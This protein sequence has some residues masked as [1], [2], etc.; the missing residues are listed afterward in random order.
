MVPSVRIL[1]IRPQ[2]EAVKQFIAA[3]RELAFTY[4]AVGSTLELLSTSPNAD[5]TQVRLGEGAVAFNAARAALGHWEQFRV[6]WA[7]PCEPL[8]AIRA[9]EVAAIAIRAMG[10]WWLNAARIVYVIEENGPVARFGFAYGTLPG[11]AESGEERFLVEWDHATDE[12]TYS[13]LAFSRP[14]HWLARLGRPLV[15]RF[16]SRFRRDSASAMQYA[17]RQALAQSH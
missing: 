15:R 9:G 10:A 5:Y 4:A 16:Q 12:V 2:Q 11:H 7:E 6:G 1:R 8:A 3:Q 17:V 14:R 13:I